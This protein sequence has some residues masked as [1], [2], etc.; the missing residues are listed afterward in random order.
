MTD[1]DTLLDTAE[2]PARQA[3][4][5]ARILADVTDG[6]AQ[7]LEGLSAAVASRVLRQAEMPVSDNVISTHRRGGCCCD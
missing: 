1:L 6:Q 3:C 4:K 7:R 2:Q 5:Y